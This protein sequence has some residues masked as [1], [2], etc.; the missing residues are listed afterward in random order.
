MSAS[1]PEL[2][3]EIRR[4]DLT[5]LPLRQSNSIERM[6]QIVLASIL[7]FWPKEIFE[8]LR[9]VFCRFSP[10]VLAPDLVA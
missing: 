10:R 7:V 8:A 2:T 4:S 9:V 5:C 6:S 1:S 3:P